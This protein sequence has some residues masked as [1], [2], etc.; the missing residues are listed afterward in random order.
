VGELTSVLLLSQI[1]GTISYFPLKA[2][3]TFDTR[4]NPMAITNGIFLGEAAVVKFF[5]PFEWN[6]TSRKLTFDFDEIA[7]FGLKFRLPKGGAA[8]LGAASGLGAKSNV[9]RAKK[10]LPAFFNW[11]S[12]ND[13]VTTIPLHPSIYLKRSIYDL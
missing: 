13:D 11:I 3:Q 9:A 7:L 5:G 12:A 10:E 2:I 6:E 8:E 4:V 1:G